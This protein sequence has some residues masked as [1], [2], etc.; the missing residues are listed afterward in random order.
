[1]RLID[2]YPLI[3]YLVNRGKCRFCDNRIP[4][5]HLLVELLGGLLFAVSFLI[6]GGTVEFAVALVAIVVLL[7]A[8]LSDI[9]T[10][11]VYDRVWIAG[12][13]PLAALRII[14]GTFLP[15]L[16]SAGLLFVVMLLLA[17]AGEKLLRKDALGGGDVK[18]FLFIGFVLTWDTGLL[19]LFLSSLLGFAFAILRKRKG[20]ELPFVPF[21]FAGVLIAHFA[22]ADVIAWY[23]RLLGA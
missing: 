19:S 9:E 21:L 6:F 16:L 18:L 10:R 17:M 15:H 8:T 1:L 11:I 2:V 5:I 20:A 7:C 13:I 14:D 12:L 22:G 4:V 23:L 3:G